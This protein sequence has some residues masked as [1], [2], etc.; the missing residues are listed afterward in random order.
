M[1][2]NIVFFL[3]TFMC[4]GCATEPYVLQKSTGQYSYQNFYFTESKIITESPEWA[5]K[6]VGKKCQYKSTSYPQSEKLAAYKLQPLTVKEINRIANNV[7]NEKGELVRLDFNIYFNEIKEVYPI[8]NVTIEQYAEDEFKRAFFWDDPYILHP[9][10]SEETWWLIKASKI[11]PGM[12]KDQVELSWGEFNR[13]PESKYV[14]DNYVNETYKINNLYL[15]FI[16][17]TLDSWY[18]TNY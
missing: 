3:C 4:A 2:K 9:N 10:W 12:N 6:Y 16:N 13:E 7:Y 15:T 5:Y 11:A 8:R 18:E 1:F 14:S 17:G